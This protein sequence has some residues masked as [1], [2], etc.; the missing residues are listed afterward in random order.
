MNATENED[1]DSV[2]ALLSGGCNPFIYCWSGKK[3]MEM[4]SDENIREVI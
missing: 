3:L 4:T 1:I 2:V